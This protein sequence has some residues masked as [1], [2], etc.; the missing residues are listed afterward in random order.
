MIRRAANL[1]ACAVTGWLIGGAIGAAV[2]AAAAVL[3]VVSTQLVGAYVAISVFAAAVLSVVEAK[4]G[5]TIR[6]VNDRPI[7]AQLGQIAGIV[8]VCWML[9]LVITGGD[10]EVTDEPSES[11]HDTEPSPVGGVLARLRANRGENTHLIGG[12]A[13]VGIG[14]IAQAGTGLLFWALAAKRVDQAVLGIATAMFTA[15]QFVNYATALGLPET[16]GRFRP[17]DR[18]DSLFRETALVSAGAS[19]VAA[20]IYVAVIPDEAAHQLRSGPGPF[21]LFAVLAAVSSWAALVDARLMVRRRWKWVFWRLALA[22]A[23]RLP[24]VWLVPRTSALAIFAVLAGPIAASAIIGTIVLYR[25]AGDVTDD[26]HLVADGLRGEPARYAGVNWLA[27][28]A[29]GAPQF[30]LPVIVTSNVSPDAYANFY[31][32][33]TIAAVAFILPVTVGRVMLT[34]GSRSGADLARSTA[35]ALSLSLLAMIVATA[36]AF[37]LAGVLPAVLGNDYADASRILPWIV[38]GGIPW[39]FTSVALANARVRADHPATLAMTVVMAIAIVGVALVLVPR[40]GI[41]GAISAWAIGNVVASAVAAL[42]LRGDRWRPDRDDVG[43]DAT[44]ADQDLVGA[45]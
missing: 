41:D 35:T 14:F 38:A 28:L 23:V 11:R 37:V 25:T 7:T 45:S 8:L 26:D 6:F 32:A 36:G 3:A 27:H 30:V 42:L 15:V 20:A 1:V 13:W 18:R 17:R 33:W 39:A 4:P 22:G 2:G 19:V 34:E 12:S 31:L 24:L 5:R 40:S 21:V 16:L 10:A 9:S 43:S 44:A 29:I